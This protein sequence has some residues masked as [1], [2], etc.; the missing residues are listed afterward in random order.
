ML[1]KDARRCFQP[2]ARNPHGDPIEEQLPCRRQHFA[3]ERR[4]A[5][6]DNPF[7]DSGRHAWLRDRHAAAS[8]FIT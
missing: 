1:G 3:V 6:G 5:A 8:S 7:A 2:R 4:A